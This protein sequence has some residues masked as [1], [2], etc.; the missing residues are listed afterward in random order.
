M[1]KYQHQSYK[2]AIEPLTPL[3][4]G[5]GETLS[6]TGE[7]FVD[8]SHLY[9]LDNDKL[10]EYLQE[11]KKLIQYIERIQIEGA[12]FKF[13][14]ELTDLLGEPDKQSLYDRLRNEFKDI[15]VGFKKGDH[16]KPSDNNILRRHIRTNKLAYIPGSSLKGLL[17]TAIVFER[18]KA[19]TN[20]FEYFDELIEK[21][22]EQRSTHP[23]KE[24]WAI[25]EK[26]YATPHEPSADQLRVSDSQ[27]VEDKHIVV[28]QVERVHFY[29]QEET[30]LD[31]LSECIAPKTQVHTC[32]TTYA[33]E[34]GLSD[35][36]PTKNFLSKLFK[37][38]N[39]HTTA[40]LHTEIQL[41][42]DTTTQPQL[43][44]KLIED[45]ETYLQDLQDSDNRY[46]IARLGQGKSIFHQTIAALISNKNRRND[47]M[48]IIAHGGKK[49]IVPRTR[50]ITAKDQEM[51]GWVK[52]AIPPKPIIP[53]PE[54]QA[55]EVKIGTIIS[56]VLVTGKKRVS[57]I[58]N[59]E[60]KNDI[61]LHVNKKLGFAVPDTD[62]F[63][64]VAIKEMAK[65]GR[66]TQV[67]MIR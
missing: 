16:Y 47:F 65:D 40:L 66:I 45:L 2:I 67:T 8:G 52:I 18:I 53:P 50:S 1:S 60:E 11:K 4:V 54:N 48:E 43:R 19:D 31:W 13:E 58:L 24:Q 34:S 62:T 46:A 5:S 6:S 36:L 32:L 35:D 44:Q 3:H 17:R 49:G 14:K 9:F 59:G 21:C 27:T 22:I 37:I 26:Q 38:L 63:V 42:Q 29:S 39:Q 10:M 15:Q 20:A 57:F 30:G 7:Y 55:D 41:L 56:Q 61:T 64:K 51:L 23:I 28:E 12:K 33:P 25:W